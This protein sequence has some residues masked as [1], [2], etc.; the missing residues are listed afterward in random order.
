MWKQTVRRN[1]IQNEEDK[2]ENIST[3]DKNQHLL[4]WP[5]WHALAYIPSLA[6]PARS[7]ASHESDKIC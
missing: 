3:Y 6:D 1:E 2:D 5:T 4:L 7:F